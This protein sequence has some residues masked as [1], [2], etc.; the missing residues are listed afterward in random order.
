MNGSDDADHDCIQDRF[1]EPGQI[2]PTTRPD[3]T[4]TLTYM[5]MPST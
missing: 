5:T 2:A 4:F 1:I 3:L